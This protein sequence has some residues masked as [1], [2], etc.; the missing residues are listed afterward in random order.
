MCL[1]LVRE[2]VV[3][4]RRLVEAFTVGA[5][6]AFG[7]AGGTLSPGAAA[8]LAVLDPTLEWRCDPARFYSKSR[9]SPWKG[10]TLTGR[11]THTFVDGRLVHELEKGGR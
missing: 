8:D 10:A 3:D 4:A 7:L 5:A 9:N 11:C 1:S 2:R 6:R